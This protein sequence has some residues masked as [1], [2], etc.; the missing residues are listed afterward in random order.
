MP[1]LS[2]AA[3]LLLVA[4]LV[5][6]AVYSAYPRWAAHR[7][8]SALTAQLNNRL[9]LLLNTR[10]ALLQHIDW[11][12]A[13][14]LSERAAALTREVRVMDGEVEALRKDLKRLQTDKRRPQ[15]LI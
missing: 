10:E 8:R 9:S 13:D 5:A 1:L 2:L 4:S 3:L 11:A 15:H 12:K 6:L 14:R 7:Q